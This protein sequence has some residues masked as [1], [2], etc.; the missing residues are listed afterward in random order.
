MSTYKETLPENCPFAD[1]KE[2]QRILFR[3]F[4]EES[5]SGNNFMCYVSINPGR[6]DLVTNCKAYG[7]SFFDSR[8]VAIDYI[9]R[10]PSLGRFVAAVEVKPEHGRLMLTNKRNGHYTLWL[11]KSFDPSKLN[12]KI[13]LIQ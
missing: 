11:Y 6:T 8:E 7:L 4:S 2:D 10:N 1:A 13:E 3:I 12:C 5:P 9:K